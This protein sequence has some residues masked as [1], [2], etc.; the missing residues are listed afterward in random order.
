MVFHL[1]IQKLIIT[2]LF[3]DVATTAAAATTVSAAPFT[4]AAA[5]STVT[6]GLVVANSSLLH[7]VQLF[8]EQPETYVTQVLVHYS[9]QNIVL[10]KY[11]MKNLIS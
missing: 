7:T 4:A 6:G 8:F 9:N 1:Y 10:I 2:P 11:H 5:S 3:L